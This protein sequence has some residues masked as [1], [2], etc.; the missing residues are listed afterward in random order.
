MI[1]NCLI[2]SLIILGF[3]CANTDNGTKASVNLKVN[4]CFD[5]F[6]NDVKVCLDSV[7]NESRCPTGLVC[8]W[9][10]DAVAAFTLTKNKNITRF[11]LH[12]NDKFQKDTLIDG[13]T[14]KLLNIFPYPVVNQQI[15]PKNYIV[16]ISVTE[17]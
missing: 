3:S 11:N 17:N 2:L 8:V 4:G 7:F 6:E 5:K 12:V 1:K 10:G 16:D 9:E 13:I 14:I 15:D